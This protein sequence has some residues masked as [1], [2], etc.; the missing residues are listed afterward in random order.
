MRLHRP[1][2]VRPRRAHPINR[3]EHPHRAAKRLRGGEQLILTDH[4]GVGVEILGHLHAVL[5]PPGPDAPYELRQDFERA[6]RTHAERLLVRIRDHR[7]GLEDGQYIGFLEALYPGE[8][9]FFLPFIAVQELH[10]AWTR[11]DAGVHLAV[12]GRRVHPWYG[13]YAPTRTVHLELFATWLSA[14]TGSRERAYDI[15]TG[16]GILAFLLAKAG[17]ERILATDA[18]PNAVESVRRDLVRHPAPIRCAVGD[19]FADQSGEADVIVFNPPWTQ[20]TPTGLVDQGL[21]FEPGLFER[22]FDQAASH[23]RPDGRVVMVFSNVIELVQPH[24][25]H[26]IKAAI[27]RGGWTLVQK[28]Q[29]KV[30]PPPGPDGRR[31]RTRERV[32]IWEL[33]P[34]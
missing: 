2:P 16:C 4:Y 9:D 19:L 7:F 29:R 8:R 1:A 5:D 23:L 11:F 28:L 31:R 30:K 20:G 21:V 22:F 34:A 33:T 3:Q 13:T 26:P 12:L 15:G 25:P 27:E 17:F 10:G 24:V 14:Y 32:E 6:F 18:N